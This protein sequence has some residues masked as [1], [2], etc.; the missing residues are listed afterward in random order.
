MLTAY[1]N[2]TRRLLANPVA[3]TPLY[4]TADLTAYINYARG[5]I[6]GEAQCIRRLGALTT[7]IGQRAYNFSAI[8]ITGAAAAGIDS[9]IH[10][11]GI[12]YQIASGQQRVTARPWEWFDLYAL[13][14]PVYTPGSPATWA[15]L[16]QGSAPGATGA[17]GGGSFYIDPVPDN[18]YALVLDCVCYPLALVA[19]G[20][21]EALPYLWTDAVPFFAAYWAFLSSQGGARQADADRMFGYYQEFMKR[22][23]TAANPAVLNYQYAQANDPVQM[24]KLG[25]RPGGGA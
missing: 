12:Q 23:R 18:A 10:V 25:I 2:Q 4:A 15:Q 14:N 13:N 6:A 1:I 22:A 24:L 20:D 21:P 9:A 3:P 5:Q 16:G 7:T 19:D 17:A 11:R 8:T